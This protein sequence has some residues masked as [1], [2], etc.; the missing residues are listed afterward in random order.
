MRE[1]QIYDVICK[2]EICVKNIVV[3]MLRESNSQKCK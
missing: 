3:V 2:I 1:Y